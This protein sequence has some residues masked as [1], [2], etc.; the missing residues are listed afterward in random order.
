MYSTGPEMPAVAGVWLLP[1]TEN[2]DGW[3]RAESR[4]ALSC[5]PEDLDLER[6]GDLDLGGLLVLLID[7]FLKALAGTLKPP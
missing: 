5:L 6:R 7:P 4:I 3:T 1:V 2:G